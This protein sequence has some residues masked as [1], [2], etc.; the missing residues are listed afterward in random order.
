MHSYGKEIVIS[1]IMPVYNAGQYLDVAIQSILNQSFQDFELILIDDGSSDGSSDKCD[2]YAGD[3]KRIVVVH[4]TNE[5]ICA[6]R[7]K[8]ISIAKGEYIGFCDH[9]D[10]YEPSYL[11]EIVSAIN[12]G[13]AD[14]IKCQFASIYE[15]QKVF[16]NYVGVMPERRNISAKELMADYPLFLLVERAVW[17]GIY[18]AEFL[19]SNGI[20]FSKDI[21][22]GNEDFEFNISCFEK[23]ATISTIAKTLYRHYVR[24]GQSTDTLF[25]KNK[26]DSIILV[27]KKERSLYCNYGMETANSNLLRVSERLNQMLRMLVHSNCDLELENK[28]HY[29]DVLK[30]TLFD[31]AYKREK[32]LLPIR[33]RIQVWLFLQ[34]YYDVLIF[35]FEVWNAVK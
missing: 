22:Y 26:I 3:D 23:G 31:D 16:R 4:Q 24:N 18:S 27:G 29:L 11:S 1:I 14:I 28:K 8:G 10:E 35:L 21:K 9:D 33:K 13:S 2:S 12:G 7:N 25:S 19:R 32:G 15:G 30:E 5:G 34:G 6:A 20:V 17:N